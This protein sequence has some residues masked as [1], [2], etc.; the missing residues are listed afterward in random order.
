MEESEQ[1]LDLKEKWFQISESFKEELDEV[2]GKDW[3][4]SSEVGKLESVLLRRPGKE[5]DAVRDPEKWR[6]ADTVD[7][8]KMRN[9]HDRLA[10][11]YRDHGATVHYVE[12]QREDRPNG[13]YMRD[14]VF[15]TPEGAIVCRPAIEARMGEQ[16]AV[17]RALADLG[18]PI[19]RTIH[20]NG[21]FEGACAMWVDED[22][23]MLGWGNR[24][25][26]E[27]INQVKDTLE[28][29]GVEDF[30]DYHIP[31]GH[32]HIDGIINLVDRR[33]AVMFP[34]QTSHHV[35]EELKSRGFD[36]LAAP[37][38]PE[39]KHNFAINAVALEPGKVVLPSGSPEMEEMLDGKGIEVISLQMDEIMKGRGGPH[40]MT[41]PLKRQ[42]A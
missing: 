8:E 2:W 3:G 5:V 41:V 37:S 32:A 36:L 13:L 1:Y 28:Y 18:V 7:P 27:G 29:L 6:W 39:V 14:L 15:M 40:C 12:N 23:V 16:E 31:F 4:V 19:L 24:A 20:G 26:E 10:Q 33:T 11:C 22:T 38:I 25:N 21:V 35:W 9:Q 34:W 30:I 17:A 42:T